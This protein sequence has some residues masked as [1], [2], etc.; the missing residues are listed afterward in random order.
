MHRAPRVSSPTA[1]RSVPQCD[2]QSIS[3]TFGIALADVP[4]GDIK[5]AEPLPVGECDPWLANF[6][7]ILTD[8][9]PTGAD[10]AV[11]TEVPYQSFLPDIVK[12][13]RRIIDNLAMNPLQ[14]V[15]LND[16]GEPQDSLAIPYSFDTS[17]LA[18]GDTITVKATLHFRHLPPEFVRG[19]AAA[20]QG[21]TNIT[22]SARIDDPDE[23][24]KN[25]VITDVV[26]AQTGDGPQLAC[27]G[28]QNEEGATIVDCIEDV[29]GIGAVQLN[30]GASGPGD[31]T[32]KFVD[33]W[34][35]AGVV[36]AFTV[37]GALFAGR[38][39]P[40]R[41]RRRHPATV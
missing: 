33:P 5:F 41:R 7:K 28:P 31:S 9:N 23:L 16:D 27:K 10:P 21:L 3:D 35:A 32:G 20:Q 30:G 12:T 38:D 18:A 22:P 39:R 37:A 34:L 29:S 14:S 1:T 11:F 40:T 26:S 24:T 6:Q 36:G 4:N 2:P 13:R 19:L 17:Q 8:G 25:L 15:E